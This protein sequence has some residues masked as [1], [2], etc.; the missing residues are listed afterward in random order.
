MI[1][2]E[3]QNIYFSRITAPR[4]QLLDSFTS[5]IFCRRRY[6]TI[7]FLFFLRQAALISMSQSLRFFVITERRLIFSPH[8][9]FS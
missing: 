6:A 4:E 2:A 9:A 5:T 8:C 3:G 7:D 1:D